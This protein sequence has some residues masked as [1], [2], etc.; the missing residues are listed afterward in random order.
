MKFNS[1]AYMIFLASGSIGG[2]GL[3]SSLVVWD[4]VVSFYLALVGVIALPV[5]LFARTKAYTAMD[6]PYAEYILEV[7]NPS[8][9]I[10]DA[11]A[12]SARS[13][14]DHRAIAGRFGYNGI[15]VNF[16]APRKN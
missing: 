10:F 2:I 9:T 7:L 14:D 6:D 13:P 5:S 11:R 12:A 4:P 3:L 15:E 1:T 16:S 8:E